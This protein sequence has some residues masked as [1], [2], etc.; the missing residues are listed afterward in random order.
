MKVALLH[1][2]LTNIRGGEKVFLELCEMFPEADIF[3][4]VISPEIKDIYFPGHK[5]YTSFINKLPYAEKFYKNY[6]PLMFKAARSFDLTGYDLIISSESGPVKGI[7]KPESSRHI[8]YCHTPVRYIWDMFD[9]YYNSAPLHKKCAMKLLKNYLRKQ[10]LSAAQSVDEF[11]VN[12]EFVKERVKRIYKR[13]ANVIYPPADVE[14]FQQANKENQDDYY[15]MA[16]EL[17]KYKKPD[18]VVEAF[19][20]N[21]KKLIIA[22][23]GEESNTLKARANSNITF[24]GRVSDEKLRELY[25][26][27]QALIFPGIEDFG[28][29][30]LE[31]QATGTPVIA[32][33]AGGALETVNEESGLFFSEQTPESLNSAIIKFEEI[34]ES[35]NPEKIKANTKNFS[36][37]VF[38]TKFQKFLNQN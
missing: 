35:F 27:A 4:H 28:I 17:V 36:K 16:G 11:I 9:E 31:A 12:S 8:C 14:F 24:T 19:N 37:E 30:P 5:V 25:A 33:A 29:V 10:D 6:M 18:L 26:N 15:L 38:K 23:T 3:T 32:Y 20:Q 21:G 7:K 13:D 1:Y 2:W 22:G 34:K